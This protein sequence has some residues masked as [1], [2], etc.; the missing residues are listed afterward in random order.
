MITVECNSKTY[1]YTFNIDGSY[2][3]AAHNI[4]EA[5]KRILE[6][7]EDEMNAAINKKLDSSSAFVI[8]AEGGFICM[9]KV[10]EALKIINQRLDDDTINQKLVE[11]GFIK[12]APNTFDLLKQISE[13]W[14]KALKDSYRDCWKEMLKEDWDRDNIVDEKEYKDVGR[15][16]VYG[17]LKTKMNK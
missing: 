10:G 3:T 6:M 17:R 2:I 14:D 9:D 15:D 13:E 16:E 12:S 4:E 5:K 8:D 7:I 1:S 11:E